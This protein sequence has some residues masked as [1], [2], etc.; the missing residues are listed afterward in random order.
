MRETLT[1]PPF[2]CSSRASGVSLMT[3]QMGSTSA[4]YEMDSMRPTL[5]L[6]MSLTYTHGLSII[7]CI[8][9]ALCTGNDKP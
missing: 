6:I 5:S 1:P 4:L 3:A 8:C 2:S 9:M 7:Q